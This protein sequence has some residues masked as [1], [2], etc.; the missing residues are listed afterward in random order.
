MR[1]GV[2]VRCAATGVWHRGRRARGGSLG[3][4][5]HRRTAADVRLRDMRHCGAAGGRRGEVPRLVRPRRRRLHARIGAG[6]ASLKA[7][8]LMSNALLAHALLIHAL[9]SQTLLV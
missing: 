1:R 9:A 6:S 4:G 3:A 7:H 2:D 8:A 5:I